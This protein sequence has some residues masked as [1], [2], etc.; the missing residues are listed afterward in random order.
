MGRD[1]LHSMI[2]L[3]DYMSSHRPIL[4]SYNVFGTFVIGW[5]LLVPLQG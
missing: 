5:R 1:T 4:D 3:V 2:G